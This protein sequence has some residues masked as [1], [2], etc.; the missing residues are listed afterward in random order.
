MAKSTSFKITDLIANDRIDNQTNNVLKNSCLITEKLL[1]NDKNYNYNNV[2]CNCLTCQ[3]MILF[4][5]SVNTSN[6]KNNQQITTTDDESS[7][8]S[9]SMIICIIY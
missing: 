7:S 2:L 5:W 6:P 4:N 3:A 1:K 9:I 8:K